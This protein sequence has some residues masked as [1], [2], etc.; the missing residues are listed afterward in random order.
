VTSLTTRGRQARTRIYDP[1]IVAQLAVVVLT[2]GALWVAQSLLAMPDK[3][4]VTVAN[5]TEYDVDVEV[6]A[7][8]A[9]AVTVFGRI[10][11]G[12]TRTQPNLLDP[13]EEWLISFR[14]EGSDLGEL[15]MSDAELD[16]LGH[17]IEV[18]SEVAAEA[19]AA[20]LTPSPG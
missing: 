8:D 7:P 11:R 17:T 4:A 15:R 5:P 1:A 14:H 3:V 9:A 10:E 12:S 20:G 19:L 18:P 2:V 13:G 16:D 6:R